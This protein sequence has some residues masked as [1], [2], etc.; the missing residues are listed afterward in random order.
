MIEQFG[1]EGT[2]GHVAQHLLKTGPITAGCLESLYLEF[3]VSSRI[4]IP[5]ILCT[6][7]FTVDILHSEVFPSI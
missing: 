4:G 1:L 5:E 6:K 7:P 2:G 3:W